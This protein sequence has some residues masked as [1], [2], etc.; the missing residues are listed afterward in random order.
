MFSD[1]PLPPEEPTGENPPDGAILDYYLKDGADRVTLE[2]LAP[3]GEVVR[4]FSSDDP[5][6]EVDPATLPHPTYW[7][8][9]PQSLSTEAGHHR[10]VWDL[11]YPPPRGARR[12]FSIAAVQWRTPSGPHGPFVAPGEYRVRLSVDG[13]AVERR[14]AVRLDPRVELAAEDLEHQTELSLRCYDAYHRAQE[15]REAL[16]AALAGLGD[17]DP[18]RDALR[19]LRGDGEPGDPDIL[20]G[21]IRSTGVDEETVTGLQHKLL[22]V[23]NVLQGADARPTRQTGDAVEQLEKSLAALERRWAPLQGRL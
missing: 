21:H 2:I 20:Y 7:I 6:E 15:M 12:Q 3:D 14:L 4:R 22:F 19:S 9:P 13:L 8:R 1:T 18:R 23:L 16:E 10:F 17:E 11:R 5:V